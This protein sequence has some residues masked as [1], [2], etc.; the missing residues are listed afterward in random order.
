[1]SQ[2]KPTSSKFLYQEV[3]TSYYSDFV[4]LSQLNLDCD[5]SMIKPKITQIVKLIFNKMAILNE[6][7]D[8]YAYTQH[9]SRLIV[10]IFDLRGFEIE[11]GRMIRVNENLLDRSL[12]FFERTKLDFYY[13]GSLIDRSM[14]DVSMI[15]DARVQ[16]FA[17]F[18]NFQVSI[19]KTCG[20]RHPI[21]PLVFQN[22][23]I[24]ALSF[25]NPELSLIN[26]IAFSFLEI[27]NTRNVSINLNATIPNLGITDMYRLKLDSHTFDPT[28]FSPVQSL[29]LGGVL[30]DIDQGFFKIFNRLRAITLNIVNMR[31]FFHLSNNIWLG[32]IF[33]QCDNYNTSQ[34]MIDYFMQN[35]EYSHINEFYL[36][37]IANA[38][39]Y[40]DEDFCL[41]KFFPR[42]KVIITFLSYLTRSALEKVKHEN[43]TLSMKLLEINNE[44][45]L[46][47]F[48]SPSDLRSV[49]V[50][51]TE[52]EMKLIDKK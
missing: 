15:G 30:R 41:F 32:S 51:I 43:R 11:L 2:C 31:Y 52:D 33:Q 39:D 23:Y 4:R 29:E 45:I 28:L 1:M 35:K 22:A 14:C 5:F 46:E 37:D 24:S 48:H 19:D 20:M 7:I 8:L 18:H 36:I 25:M 44:L 47:Y 17:G 42:K 21:C 12:I 38:Y 26:P 13:R 16:L 9:Q 6:T 34:D 40:P 10:Y 49:D 27:R 3:D 50:N